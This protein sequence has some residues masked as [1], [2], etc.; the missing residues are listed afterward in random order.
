MPEAVSFVKACQDFFTRG[1]HGKKLE[2]PEFKALTQDDK[3]ELRLLLIDEGY[4]VL[5]LGKTA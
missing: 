4:N 1:P 2:I 5:E 3:E